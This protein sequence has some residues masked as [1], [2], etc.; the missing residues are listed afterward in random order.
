MLFYD[1]QP[2]PSPR[3]VRIFI[4]EKGLDIPV[5]EIDLGS[6]EHM[7]P[8]F[9]AKNPDCTVPALELDD[10]SVLSET[11]AICAYLEDTFPE[12]PLIGSDA[13]SRAEVLMWNARIEQQGLAAVAE[14]FRNHAKGFTGRAVTGPENYDQ[15]PALVPRGR[16]R[17]EQFMRMM[18]AR[19]EGREF[20]AGAQFS[21]ADITALITVDMCAWIKLPIPESLANLRRWHTAVSTRPSVTGRTG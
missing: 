19:L 9:R 13:R 15:I 4:A 11:I 3:R 16:A 10:G 21:M 8:E 7:T 1:C 18:N 6:G 20:V 14:S 12:P 5:Q 17:A 2:A